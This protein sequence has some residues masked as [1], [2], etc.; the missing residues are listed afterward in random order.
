MYQ[1]DK[2]G[3]PD[4]TTP[5]AKAHIGGNHVTGFRSSKTAD[6]AG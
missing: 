4:A 6:G 5:Q 2:I 3:T 1:F